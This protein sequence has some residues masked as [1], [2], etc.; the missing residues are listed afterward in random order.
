MTPRTEIVSLSSDSTVR[1]FKDIYAEHSHSRFLVYEGS[2]DNVIGS[3]SIKDVLMGISKNKTDD[4]IVDA[5]PSL[6]ER[7]EMQEKSFRRMDCSMHSMMRTG[8]IPDNVS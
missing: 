5:L 8:S 7:I 2:E 6:V 3:I 1:N 4:E